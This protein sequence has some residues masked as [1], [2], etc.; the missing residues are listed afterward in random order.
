V[1]HTHKLSFIDEALGHR[2][3][4]NRLRELTSFLPS[5]DTALVEKEGKTLIN[6]SSNDYL[7]LARHPQVIRRSCEYASRYGA[8]ATASR[9]I[10]GTFGAH[11]QLEEK[12]AAVYKAEA[13]LL[14][15]SGFQANSTLLATLT[16]RN[17]LILADKFSHNSMLQG[18][19]LSRAELQR[20]DHNN[21]S[22]LESLLKRSR[23]KPY[24]R[25]LI[26]TE[27]IFSM[28]GD[29]SPLEEIIHLAEK[30][31]ALLY[32]DD[33]HA[34]GVWGSDGLGLAAHK[35]GIDVLLGTCGKA[36]GAYGAFVICSQKLKKYL[37]NFCPGFI[38]T[39][40]LP[41]SVIG[42]IDAALDL[43]PGMN[44]QRNSYY[45]RI[46]YLRQALQD[47]GF[48]TGPSTSQIIPVIVGDESKA[49]DLARW[50]EQRGLLAVAVRPPTVPENGSRI[51]ITLT[52]R[53]TDDHIR[54]LITALTEWKR[55]EN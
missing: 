5:E 45:G 17:S 22:H 2:R 34:A 20:F 16:D 41:P 6:F 15:N 48:D 32:V 30:Y 13:A 35:V 40:A 14:F 27:T 37:I 29:R 50:L 1:T 55:G 21:L 12:L 24:S 38:F 7:G 19:L 18:S 54:Q 31:N 28:D 4:E 53:H 49:L 36:F 11:R 25:R 42:S 39:T 47:K 44:E 33:A 26:V 3:N 8:G 9:L 10:C 51:R 23:S 43:L 46:E 52:L